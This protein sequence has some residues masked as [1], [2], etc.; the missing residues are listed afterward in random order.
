VS[1]MWIRVECVNLQVDV[2]S[3]RCDWV[4]LWG[5]E[6]VFVEW[7]TV[8]DCDVDDLGVGNCLDGCDVDL[9]RLGNYMAG[10]D[11]DLC[12]VG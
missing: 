10:C 8:G 2:N 3:I 4:T 11:E 6:M 12:G 5:G 9:C 7:I 1:V